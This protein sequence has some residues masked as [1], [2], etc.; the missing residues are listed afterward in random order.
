MVKID[1]FYEVEICLEYHD[2]IQLH[3]LIFKRQFDANNFLI[4]HYFEYFNIMFFFE[5]GID[6]NR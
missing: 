6:P 4:R 3:C 5:L 1:M 2:N